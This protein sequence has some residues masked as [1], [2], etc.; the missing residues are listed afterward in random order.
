MGI[1]I[2]ILFC[3]VQNKHQYP[4]LR[5]SAEMSA[6]GKFCQGLWKGFLTFG[7]FL[8]VCGKVM[9][10]GLWDTKSITKVTYFLKKRQSI[11]R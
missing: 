7:I 9:F 1:F 5:E 3:S 6:F 4:H 2:K 10:L 8:I 11:T